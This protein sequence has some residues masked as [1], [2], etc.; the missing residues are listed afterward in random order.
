MHGTFVPNK[1]NFRAVPLLVRVLAKRLLFTAVGQKM[2]LQTV[3]FFFISVFYTATTQ[4]I[5][6]HHRTV[7]T[8]T[9]PTV[10]TATTQ[11]IHSHHRTVHTATTQTVYKA[12]TQ[13]VYTADS[14]I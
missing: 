11:T 12:T 1:P 6:S 2:I 13:P 5:Y 8:A 3:C 4:T 9:T 14:C 7:H 10:Y